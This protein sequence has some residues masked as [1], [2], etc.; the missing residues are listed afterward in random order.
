MGNPP[1]FKNLSKIVAPLCN[2]NAVLSGNKVCISLA[3]A[4]TVWKLIHPVCVFEKKID[5]N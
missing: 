3:N 2:A 4:M 1:N 5:N